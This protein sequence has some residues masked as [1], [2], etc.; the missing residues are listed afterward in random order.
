[1]RSLVDYSAPVLTALS[2]SQRTRLEVVQNNAMRTM[3]GAPR[4]CSAC[5]MQSEARLVPL[6]TRV[7]F[8]VACRVARI[9]HRDAVQR[10]LRMA[11]M[12]DHECLRGNPWLTNT[13]RAASILGHVES[14]PWQWREADIPAPAFHPP[15]PWE[16][17]VAEVTVTPLPA[18]KAVC[19][20]QEMQQRALMSMEE[21]TEPGSAVYFTDGSVDPEGGTTGAAAVTGGTQLLWRTSDHCSSLQTELVAILHALEHAQYRPEATVVVHTD[22]L[23]ALQVLQQPHPSD[24][25]RLVTSILGSLQSLAAQGRRARLHWIPGHVGISGNEAADEAAKRAAA[26]PTVTR[27][28]L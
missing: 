3:L 28:V 23:A 20:P 4:W 18:S 12:Q 7:E 25:V 14:W 17:P 5:V 13:A 6:T 26:G 10:R 8:I 15:A 24:N 11:M 22:S 2:S 19:L 9:L 27:H 1:M 16:P 21:V